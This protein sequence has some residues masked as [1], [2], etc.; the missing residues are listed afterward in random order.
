MCKSVFNIFQRVMPSWGE[1]VSLS[2][3]CLVLGLSPAR[4]T[5]LA[6][7]SVTISGTNLVFSGS[8]GVA[9]A[10]YYILT[11]T[12]LTLSPMALWNRI[13][14]NVFSSGGRFTNSSP[15]NASVPEEFFVIGTNTPI[16]I[17]GLVAAYSFDEGSGTT[18]FDASGNG[19]NG[20][21]GG[22]SWTTS[23]K[24]GNALVFDGVSTLVTINN[25]ASLQLGT[26]MTLE[27]WVNPSVVSGAWRDV[28]YKGVDNYYLEGTSPGTGNVP[29]MGGTFASMSLY[30]TAA[31]PMNT[32]THLAATYD[33][34]TL[35][36]YV[37]G[38]QVASRA[39][40]GAIATSTNPLQ[41]GG[42]SIY[43]QFY[44][45]ML[46]EVR[47]YNVA[48]TAAQVQADMNT[49]VGDIP[50]AP[51]NLTATVI[52]PNQVNLGWVA[53]TGDLGVAGYFVE[54]S[55]GAGGSNFVQIGATSSTNYVD[56]GLVAN[57]NYSY[58][59]RATDSLGDLG[60]YSSVAVVFMG[61]SISPRVAVLTPTR[62][63]QFAVNF[64][65]IT[66]NW[67]VDGLTG[68]S[69][70]VGT[71]TPDGLYTPPNSMGTHTVTATTTNPTQTASAT[72][73]VTTNPGVFTFHNDNFRTGENTN[74]TVLSPANVNSGSFGKLFSYTL[75]GL[76][77]ASPLYVAGVTIPGKGTHNVVYVATEHDS[78]YA[79]DADGLTN[80]PLWQVSFIN[81]TSGV[82][83]VPS[84]DSDPGEDIPNEVGITG[85]PVID[86]V[87]GTLYV[88]A[89][90]KE[91]SGTTTYVQRLH[92]LDIATGAEKF[93]APV[94]I[95]A[96]V[97]GTGP[98]SS[99]GQVQFDPLHENQR[100][101]LLLTDGM[102]CFVFGS[103]GDV[104]P[105]YGWLLG[106]TATNMQHQILVYNA[107]PNAG[108]A[109][110]WMDGDGPAVDASGNL[111]FI[112]ADGL[113]DASSGGTDFG[114]S[115][116]KLS[117]AGA[118]L[119]Y[120]T[121][122]VQA[123]LYAN[124]LD[125]GAG[126]VLLLPDQ[127]GPHTHEV[128]SASKNATIY[129][130]DRDNMG[131]YHSNTD[132]IVQALVDIFP[133]NPGNDSGNFGSPVYYNG[134]VYFCAVS[135]NV[136]AF[137]LSNGLLSTSPTT[138]SAASFAYPGAMLAASGNGNSNGIL[139]AV[140]RNGLMT[141]CTLHAY[142]AGNL[143][144]ELYNSDQAGSRDSAGAD[145]KWA[146][147]LVVNGKVYVAAQNES[148]VTLNQLTVYGLLP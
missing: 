59:V 70:V 122:M 74:E 6:F 136:K 19:N 54:R 32:W 101:A 129:L 115:F 42:D 46:D 66:V 103:H 52:S 81:P 118:V 58:R 148:V 138:Q 133:S 146:I 23:G 95:Q 39:Q 82:T 131:H 10:T 106:Y 22:A 64:T 68:G 62:M 128:V 26:A 1:A 9:G 29:A 124:N 60:P 20:I 33:G 97:A 140:Q 127:A 125:L 76:T 105:Y 25:S 119:D 75:D 113:F 85:T 141:P 102:V 48:L 12:N 80:G 143:A 134:S 41:I 4:A 67:S 79:F 100:G 65:N 88:I 53:S 87:S 30:G 142:D 117:S 5:G 121:P 108:K 120:F 2:V 27:A 123:D 144:H 24:Y 31:L 116:I 63:Q 13:S 37:N 44:Q 47:V 89:A 83:T 14:T 55:Q 147:P 56:S 43:S 86:P 110:I 7:S 3:F 94:V 114:D 16:T 112:T 98:G 92:A 132:Q 34:T 35:R 28:I 57:T 15:I 18:V 38:I 21:I 77:F 96:T 72:V 93:G 17:P 45:G 11:A 91:V 73:Y 51:G 8:G 137:Q 107:A 145:A 111:Y 50:T 71:I 104:G 78:V 36:L 130:V 135:D 126:G 69:A 90:T 139:W 109:G 84:A 40:T 99:G 61:L 49:P